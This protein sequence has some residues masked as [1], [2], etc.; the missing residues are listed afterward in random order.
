M[1]PHSCARGRRGNQDRTAQHG[2]ARVDRRM[3]GLERSRISRKRPR[4]RA[5][6]A[7]PDPCLTGAE[8]RSL[9]RAQSVAPPQ[10]RLILELVSTAL[11]TAPPGFGI[12]KPSCVMKIIL[13]CFVIF[14]IDIIKYAAI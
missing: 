11:L 8:P 7:P 12:Q 4:H 2:S 9:C 10:H 14:R 5:R 6:R 13:Y 3:A 1:D